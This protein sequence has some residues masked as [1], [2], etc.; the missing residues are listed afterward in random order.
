MWMKLS[1]WQSNLRALDDM[2]RVSDGQISLHLNSLVS[3][4]LSV[5]DAIHDQSRDT[6]IH[7]YM[8]AERNKICSI[9]QPLFSQIH[10][11]QLFH[12]HADLLYACPRPHGA[13]PAGDIPEGIALLVANIKAGKGLSGPQRDMATLLR[14]LAI[15]ESHNKFKKGA[16]QTLVQDHASWKPKSNEEGS[17]VS[18]LHPTVTVAGPGSTSRQFC[19]SLKDRASVRNAIC[20]RVRRARIAKALKAFREL[21]PDS[22]KVLSQN[23]LH[24]E[25]M[26]EPFIHIEGYGH[27]LLHD[28]MESEPLGELMGQIMESK[29][30]AAIQL[31]ES[32]GLYLMPVTSEHDFLQTN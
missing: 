7:H 11:H 18:K 31:L 28:L 5:N 13:V 14:P 21:I 15:G 22:E 26:S 3:G 17:T 27:Y 19:R 6:L 9:S 2:R 4:G 29:M 16:I 10:L 24:C 23:R 1:S 12:S 32:K 20:S 25:A 30:P 8:A